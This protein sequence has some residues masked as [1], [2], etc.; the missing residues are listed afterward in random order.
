MSASASTS[1]PSASV[2]VTSIVLPFSAVTMSPGRY[3]RPL[4]MF[5]QA[6]TTASTRNGRP[7]SAIAPMV[8]TTAP[9]PAMSLFISS[10][11][12]DGLIEMPPVSNVIALPTRPRT[13]PST[14]SSGSWRR[15]I[16]LGSESAPWA[17]AANAPMP[18]AS[19]SARP[20]ISAARPPLDAISPARSASAVGVSRLAG[21][22]TS[23]R[24]RLAQCATIPARAA[25]SAAAAA[26]AP[27]RTRRSIG[28]RSLSFVFQRPASKAP[29]TVPS[30]IAR[31]CSPG[32]RRRPGSSAHATVPPRRA[33]ARWTTRDAAVRRASASRS[34]VLPT[35]T[36]AN[37]CAASS[38]SV[39]TSASWPSWPLIS[40]SSARWARRPASRP[41]S[42]APT[43]PERSR[44]G[45]RES[46]DVRLDRLGRRVD[47]GDLHLQPAHGSRRG[48]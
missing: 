18:A 9:P 48:S 7:S 5:S 44:L 31:A 32:G 12:A 42:C 36:G 20:Q 13:M 22:L 30:T 15:T 26:P 2:F 41:S 37:R 39:C 45:D 19:I 21:A 14:A 33:P 25:G 16:S 8:E 43:S 3:D 28:A 40:R 4:S 6:G 1:R 27:Q 17:T 29:R 35:P 46:E 47:D 38:P 10:M 23:S 24:Q 11:R 34:V